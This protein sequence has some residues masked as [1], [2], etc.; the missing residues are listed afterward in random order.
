[1]ENNHIASFTHNI[2][3]SITKFKNGN[4]EQ[5]QL[6]VLLL[7]Q[8]S[9]ALTS[10]DN[11]SNVNMNND[12][13]NSNSN[14]NGNGSSN[15]IDFNKNNALS[16]EQYFINDGMYYLPFSLI[17]FSTEMD[18]QKD[19]AFDKENT[20]YN[21]NNNQNVNYHEINFSQC[22]IT[23][24]SKAII[25]SINNEE[26]EGIEYL[27]NQLDVYDTKD[28]F[29]TD[30][31]IQNLN[32]NSVCNNNNNSNDNNDNSSS[33]HIIHRTKTSTGL[34]SF[35]SKTK[36][37]HSFTCHNLSTDDSSGG[38]NNNSVLNMTSFKSSNEQDKL[39]QEKHN[40]DSISP[41][42]KSNYSKTMNKKYINYIYI[43]Y[44]R[45]ITSVQEFNLIYENPEA[46]FISAY[47]KFIMSM[48]VS[49]QNVF[50]VLVREMLLS[51]N[52]LSFDDFINSFNVVLNLKGALGLLKFKFLLNISNVYNEEYMRLKDIENFME[53]IQCKQVYESGICPEIINK[54][55]LKYKQLYFFLE[56]KKNIHNEL[57]NVKK[58]EGILETFY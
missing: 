44:T 47:K 28:L 13:N 25:N 23:P 46:N 4:I 29:Y 17:S 3:N 48:G 16:K 20:E 41:S 34:P 52:K 53:L 8:L 49:V 11:T 19:K 54:M 43:H 10:F 5:E 32:I 45:I 33:T 2:L 55:I 24:N 27:L 6:N 56:E 22:P 35:P 50:T 1:M 51:K 18:F 14:S 40:L 30:Y 57:F 37:S 31:D 26:E 21:N 58:L 9:Q 12:N 36:S 38:D 39:K 7:F 15:H 42:I